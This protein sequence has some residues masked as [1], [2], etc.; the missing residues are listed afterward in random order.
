ME[1]KQTPV[2]ALATVYAV[3]LDRC[4][5][6]SLLRR[7]VRAG[8]T[9]RLA[10]LEPR[11]ER[12]GFFPG[13]AI[14]LEWP[15][16]AL[17]VLALGKSA[18]RSAI[19]LRRL[20]GSRIRETLVIAPPGAVAPGPRSRAVRVMR[21][22]HPVPKDGSLLAGEAVLEFVSRVGKEDLLLVALSG[23][24]SA[25][26]AAP[27]EGITLDDLAATNRALLA[28]GAPIEAMNAIRGQ[29]SRIKNGRLARACRGSLVTLVLSDVGGGPE[30]VGS[31]PTLAR[32]VDFGDA[33]SRYG[34]TDALPSH[35]LAT[36][37]S[38]RPPRR[39][40]HPVVMLAEPAH[41]VAAA[42]D[43]LT[44]QGYRVVHA[45]DRAESP[46]LG[47]RAQEMVRTARSLAP[48]E[49]WVEACEP[50]VKLPRHPGRGG[51]NGHLALAVARGIAGASDLAALVAGSD[52]IDGT[53][54]VAGAVVNGSTWE[55][56]S[57][58][59]AALKHFDSGSL[60]EQRP[61][62]LTVIAPGPTG[63]NLRDLHILA[64]A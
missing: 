40:R 15:A 43:A 44:R 37:A 35:V 7:A 9:L 27:A 45:R 62:G 5:P 64:R 33:L 57:G 52:G 32:S 39:R 24:A 47:E 36:I 17:F 1:P 26:V 28:S 2:E 34:L 22:E 8:P 21:G 12:G 16:G 61:A 29:L 58:G 18:G 23:G 49:A 11:L 59:E 54:S 46:T 51:R 48:G 31:G 19:G 63:V 25:L 14:E 55:R 50:V 56:L 60:L 30:L 13:D 10:S 38:A 41:L 6:E 53:A 4:A 42:A 3:T 20:L